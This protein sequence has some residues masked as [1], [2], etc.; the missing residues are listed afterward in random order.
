MWFHSFFFAYNKVTTEAYTHCVKHCQLGVIQMR[1]CFCL[2]FALLEQ[3]DITKFVHHKI[4]RCLKSCRQPDK[5]QC[6][7]GL[8]LIITVYCCQ[9]NS[10]SC[11]AGYLS[12]LVY[13][14]PLN[15]SMLMTVWI[16]ICYTVIDHFYVIL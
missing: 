7:V 10:S 15:L 13:F 2:F 11:Y 9:S 16:L 12:E 8:F 3:N 4:K 1:I 14:I 6:C 5:K